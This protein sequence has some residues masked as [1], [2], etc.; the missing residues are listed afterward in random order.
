MLIKREV[1][2]L[3]MRIRL[4]DDEVANP[5]GLVWILRPKASLV[6]ADR[7]VGIKSPIACIGQIQHS[8]VRGQVSGVEPVIQGNLLIGTS[9]DVLLPQCAVPRV[10]NG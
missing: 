4:N 5:V 9:G 2:T 6:D 3:R 10:E 8:S 7:R 1:R